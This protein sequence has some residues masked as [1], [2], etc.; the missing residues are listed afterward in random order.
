MRELQGEHTVEKMCEVFEVSRSG[1][2]TWLQRKLSSRTLENAAIV[3]MIKERRKKEEIMETYGSPRW[4]AELCA[5]G[6]YCN[7]K[8]VAR[9]MQNNGIRAR[10]R[11]KHRNS[12]DSKHGYPLAPNVLGQDFHVENA[13]EVYLS[14]GSYIWTLEGW[15]MLVAVLDLGTKEVVGFATGKRLSSSLAQKALRQAYETRKPAPGLIHHSDRGGEYAATAYQDLLEECKMIPSMSRKGNCWDNA[16]MESFFA[17]LK[18]ELVYH[19]RFATRA[20]ASLKIFHYIE[21]FYNTTRRH[22]SIGY[23]SPRDYAQKLKQ[24]STNPPYFSVHHLG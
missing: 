20:E 14:D 23:L 12:T 19:E 21:G 10:S 15:L 22:S 16:P 5:M 17:T 11:K 4:T 9:L 1:Y 2:Y 7:K 6:L 3:A 24:Q 8:R 13:D 18:K